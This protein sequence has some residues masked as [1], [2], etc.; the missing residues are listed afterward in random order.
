[1]PAP[2]QREGDRPSVCSSARHAVCQHVGSVR[3]APETCHDVIRELAIAADTFV[4]NHLSRTG[5]RAQA[6]AK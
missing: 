1:M 4:G 2:R 5:E 3:F 6:R